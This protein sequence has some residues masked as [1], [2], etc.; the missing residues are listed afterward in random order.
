MPRA[1]VLVLLLAACVPVALPQ[2]EEQ[3]ARSA[4]TGASGNRGNVA[5]GASTGNAAIGIGGGT[6][7]IGVGTG[8]RTSAGA[9][10]GMTFGGPTWPRLPPETVYV[11]CVRDR[12]GQDPSVNMATALD[13]AAAR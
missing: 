9:G 2:A 4:A 12:T 11:N 8:G 13:R 5:V 7:G 1:L 3:C 10:I 6:V